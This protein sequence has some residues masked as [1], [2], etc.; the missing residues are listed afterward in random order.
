VIKM[1]DVACAAPA[2]FPTRK[3][4][5]GRGTFA[6]P[7]LEVAMILPVASAARTVPAGKASAERVS[8][9]VAVTAPPKNAVPEVYWL[10][11]T[12]S[13]EG[14][15][16]VPIPTLPPF[17]HELPLATRFKLPL[18]EVRPPSLRYI[19]P[20]P[21]PFTSIKPAKVEVAV[22]EVVVKDPASALIPRSEEPVTE[23]AR[24]GEVVPIPTFPLDPII[25]RAERVE[26]AVPATVVVAK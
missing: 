24:H 19:E 14:G 26:V 3:L 17:N 9:E 7:I 20:V 18:E 22:V 1:L 25:V 15:V 5:L 2:S 13:V 6:R 11:W 10:P 4:P 8:V 12:E 23:S 21:V 16:V